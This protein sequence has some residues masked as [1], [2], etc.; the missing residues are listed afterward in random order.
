MSLTIPEAY[1]RCHA[2]AR[3]SRTNFYWSFAPLPAR[4]RQAIEAV[5]AWMRLTD[6]IVDGAKTPTDAHNEL[7]RWR[8]ALVSEPGDD[9]VLMALADT[10]REFKIPR[11][12]FL[13][14]LDGTE[15]D[16]HVMRYE[17]FA[18]LYRY[19]Y[20]VASCVGLIVL[21]IFGYD[22]ESAQVPAEAC[23]IAFQLT[24]IL[25]DVKEDAARGR[26]YLPAEDLRQF[27]VTEQDIMQGRVTTR[28]RELIRFEMNRTRGYY[29]QAEPLLGM[30]QPDARATLAVMIGVYRGLLGKLEQQDGDVF[31]R[32][33]RL[34]G[35]EKA[36]VVARNWWRYRA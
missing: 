25:R 24:N 22:D 8:Q 36:V 16:L 17:T 26:I 23:G 28:F 15:T 3:G 4:K 21:P 9:P 20:R 6:D 10:V 7:R 29:R 18:E 11:Q 32:R 19:C 27:G 14:L 35:L 5:Y 34:N 12:P 2:I 13:D 1:A 33:V 31:T 30:I